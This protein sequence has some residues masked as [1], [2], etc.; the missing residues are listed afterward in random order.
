[1]SV[2]TTVEHVVE[3]DAAP[4]TVYRLWTTAAGLAAW[5]GRSAEADPRPGGALRVD[6]DGEHVMA[7]EFV[8]LDE[9][10][11][12]VFTFGWEGG[13]LPP[14]ASTVDIRIDPTS[15]GSRV[16]LRHSGL[17]VEFVQIHVEG[18]THFL[19]DKLT[20]AGASG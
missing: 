3:I 10:H 11:R 4:H 20:R 7:G 2:T 9:P 6:V 15:A 5:F 14:G 16:T 1:M 19:G 13:E 18:W 12:V 17:P 8:Q